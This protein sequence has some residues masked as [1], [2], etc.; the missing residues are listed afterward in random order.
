MAIIDFNSRFWRRYRH[1]RTAWFAT[2]MFLVIMLIGACANILANDRP[3]LMSYKGKLYAPVFVDYLP[4]EFGKET[5]DVGFVVDYFAFEKEINENG[6]AIFPPIKQRPNDPNLNFESLPAP[7]GS[8]TVVS[9]SD[10][11]P[12]LAVTHRLGTDTAGR[13][14]V[15]RLIY[16][17][18]TS[19][20]MSI[21]ITA[22]SLVLGVILGAIMGYAGGVFDILF[23]RLLETLGYFPV[24]FMI[25]ILVAFLESPSI[26]AVVVI[27][28]V[29]GL[30]PFAFYTRGQVLQARKL[31]YV[32]AAVALGQQQR[33]IMFRHILPNALSPILVLIPFT[34][35]ANI[36]FLAT[37]DFL[38][39]GVQPPTASLGAILRSGFEDVGNRSWLVLY[40]SIVLIAILLLV[41][42][43]GDGVRDGMDPHATL[44]R[45]E[46]RAWLRELKTNKASNA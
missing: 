13:D 17:L 4:Y 10:T 33:T 42:F 27:F 37:I 34:I 31:T 21:A 1:N 36:S 20:G 38:G 18:R 25:I 2:W 26:S 16:G 24:I 46:F 8:T 11:F 45:K 5:S 44:S 41:N 12:G 3:L 15:T 23:G 35:T 29:L 43:I 22:I 28:A 32:E 9:Q 14:L 30:S 7:P 19:L 6:W 39:F 40:S